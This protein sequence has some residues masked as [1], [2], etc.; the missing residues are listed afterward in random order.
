MDF[1]RVP[2]YQH[3]PNSIKY[4]AKALQIGILWCD[5]VPPMARLWNFGGSHCIGPKIWTA[6][7]RGTNIGNRPALSKSPSPAI[8]SVH[9]EQELGPMELV[10]VKCLNHSWSGWSGWASINLDLV[11]DSWTPW[12]PSFGNLG[13]QR[14]RLWKRRW[15]P[16]SPDAAWVAARLWAPPSASATGWR[17][18]DTPGMGI[19]IIWIP[20]IVILCDIGIYWGW[21]TI[22]IT[23]WPH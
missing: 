19:W 9:S 23:S 7:R 13:F 16:A 15:G 22:G 20:P 3:Y 4:P 2:L 8:L 1:I 11:A 10:A 5:S 17:G 14:R 18:L 6:P 12:I 21:F